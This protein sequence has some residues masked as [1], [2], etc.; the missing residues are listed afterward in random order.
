MALQHYPKHVSFGLVQNIPVTNNISYISVL[1]KLNRGS[2][3]VCSQV[4]RDISYEIHDYCS[5]VTFVTSLPGM[6][7][8]SSWHYVI[9]RVNIPLI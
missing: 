8:I 9:V 4:P 1:N 7:S 2:E 5:D 3:Y 6:D